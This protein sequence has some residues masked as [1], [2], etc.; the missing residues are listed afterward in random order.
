MGHGEH[1]AE[2]HNCP[3]RTW[4]IYLPHPVPVLGEELLG[5][6]VVQHRE[7]GPQGGALDPLDHRVRAAQD[8]QVRRFPGVDAAPKG[9]ARSAA[10]RRYWSGPT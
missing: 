6:R 5:L 4:R 3:E 9:L 7:D 2:G 10:K 1:A 8:V